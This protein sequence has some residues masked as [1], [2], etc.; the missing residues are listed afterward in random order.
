[1][2]T[3]TRIVAIPP[4]L[5]VDMWPHLE[6]HIRKGLTAAT[7]VTMRDIVDGVSAGTDQLWAVFVDG[8][9]AAAFVTALHDEPTSFFVGV[10][11]LGG[12]D[13]NRWADLLGETMA[14]Y[15]MQVGASC[16]RFHGREAWSRVLPSYQITGHNAGHAVF[17]RRLH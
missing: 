10:Y 14:S 8:E 13:L 15:G 17:E 3:E 16:V 12:R 5:V 11:G 2:N 1:M 9:V 7:D 6:P 4:F